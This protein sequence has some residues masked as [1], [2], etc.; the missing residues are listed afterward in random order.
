L[1]PAHPGGKVE[2]ISSEK[3]EIDTETAMAPM[4]KFMPAQAKSAIDATR[5]LGPCLR[6]AIAASR[7]KKPRAKDIRPNTPEAGFKRCPI[8]TARNDRTSQRLLVHQLADPNSLSLV[9][10]L[11][12]G[13]GMWLLLPVVRVNDLGATVFFARRIMRQN[14]P[15]NPPL[16]LNLLASRISVRIN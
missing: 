15:R 3:R 12:I 6:K 9:P 2:V 7:I 14:L 8:L 5:M 16:E 11:I 1:S 4:R 13:F 10:D